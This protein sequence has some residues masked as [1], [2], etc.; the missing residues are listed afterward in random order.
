MPHNAVIAGNDIR[1]E[2][3][4][5]GRSIYKG[6][7]VAVKVIPNKRSAFLSY[8]GAEIGVHH[9]DVLTGSGF[10]W[11]PL[12]NGQIPPNAVSSGKQKDG[13]RLYIGRAYF[14]GSMC[15][16]K[17][18]P[19]HG[20]LYIP[21]AGAEHRISQ[22]EVLVRAHNQHVGKSFFYCIYINIYHF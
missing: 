19:S 15:P 20:C 13:E 21:F 7:Q 12:S 11:V 16:G 18:H 6:D 5:I 8:G 3:I 10:S 1:G 2:P 9:F 17:V 14:Q 4:Y 22:Y